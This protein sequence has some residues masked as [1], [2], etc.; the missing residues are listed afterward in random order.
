MKSSVKFIRVFFITNII[1]GVLL[2]PG[3]VKAETMVESS[4]IPEN[5]PTV[6]FFLQNLNSMNWM[7]FFRSIAIIGV[8][9][10]LISYLYFLNYK[11]KQEDDEFL[12]IWEKKITVQDERRKE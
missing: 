7:W 12:N 4:T 10:A 5:V 3:Y 11:S 9:I 2:Y 8:L 6:H 1:F